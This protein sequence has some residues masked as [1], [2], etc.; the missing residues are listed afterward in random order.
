M[1]AEKNES[2]EGDKEETSTNVADD[3]E[4]THVGGSDTTVDDGTTGDS[5][6]SDNVDS[7]PTGDNPVSSGEAASDSLV[8]ASSS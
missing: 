6:T 7:Q 2:K 4:G 5:A 1:N 8:P 3:D